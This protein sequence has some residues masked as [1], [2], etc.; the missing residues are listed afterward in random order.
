M[1]IFSFGINNRTQRCVQNTTKEIQRTYKM[2]RNRLPNARLYFPVINYSELLVWEERTHLDG[3]N[4]YIRNINVRR[5]TSTRQ[6]QSGA[7]FNPLDHRDRQ[8]HPGTLGTPVKLARSI[9]QIN[10]TEKLIV[11]LTASFHLTKSQESLLLKGLSFVPAPRNQKTLKIELLKDLQKYHRR[12]KL[13]AF[14]EKK[15]KTKEKTPFTLGSDWTPPLS[16]LPT[17]VHKIIDADLHAFRHLHWNWREEPNLTRGEEG[18]LNLFKN[19][20]DIV[21]KPADKG[22]A[23]VLFDRKDYLWEGMAVREHRSLYSSR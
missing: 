4:E 7:G 17:Q 9:R 6:V 21:I 16:R 2:A 1:V 18:A 19:N 12:I 11:N 22:N 10:S 14:F 8:G 23:V 5:K 15:K 13:E 3:V 20:T